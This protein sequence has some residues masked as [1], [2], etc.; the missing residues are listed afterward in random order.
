MDQLAARMLIRHKLVDG[1]LPHDSIPR[2]WGGP[3]SGETCDGCEEKI[4]PP[5][6]VM[7]G[8]AVSPGKRAVQFHVA[9]FNLWIEERTVP[10]H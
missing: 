7:E 4:S 10:G 1:R 3:S 5:Q 8:V 9:C 6:F 2:V